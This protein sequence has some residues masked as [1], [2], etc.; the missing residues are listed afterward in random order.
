VKASLFEDGHFYSPVVDPDTL[1]PDRIWCARTKLP[2]I[3]FRPESQRDVLLRLFPAY[4]ADFDYPRSP[5]QA[6]ATNG[7][8]AYFLDNDQYSNFDAAA[9]FVLMRE[10]KPRQVIEIGSGFSSLLMADVS[11]RFLDGGC[12]IRCVEPYPRDFLRDPAS[13]LQLIDKRVQDVPLE[14][15]I[16]LQAGDW[17]FIDS[18]HVTKTGSDVN[19][20]FFEVIPRLSPGVVVHVHDIFLPDDYPRSWVMDENRSWNE[21]YL[22]QAYL[23]F[24]SRARVVFGTA[25]ARRAYPEETVRAL[26]GKVDLYGGSLWFHTS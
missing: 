23:T 11:R 14:E 12:S 25:Y 10:F 22:V 1:D 20:L 19:F 3:D 4:M 7:R 17:L 18:S 21:Q 6:S 13:G 2:G 5:E 26:G 16:S 8:Q 24:N 9:L 15:L